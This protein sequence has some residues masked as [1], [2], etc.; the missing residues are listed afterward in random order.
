MAATQPTGLVA[1]IVLFGLALVT[2]WG[3]PG[4]AWL[5]S[6]LVR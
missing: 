3:G 5:A 2:S 4:W 1:L 6:L